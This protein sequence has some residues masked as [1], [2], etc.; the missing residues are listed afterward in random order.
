VFHERGVLQ[1]LHLQKVIKQKYFVLKKK[2][3]PLKLSMENLVKIA[4][5]WVTL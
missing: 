4:G 1:Y 2:G 3:H 5:K